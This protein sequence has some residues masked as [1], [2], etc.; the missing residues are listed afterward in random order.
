MIEEFAAGPVLETFRYEVDVAGL[1]C[2][3]DEYTGSL[4]GLVTAD[5]E[6]PDERFHHA[7]MGGQGDYRQPPLQLFGI[8]RKGGWRHARIRLTGASEHRLVRQS[9]R[10][11]VCIS[12]FQVVARHSAPR[13]ASVC[14]KLDLVGKTSQHC[15]EGRHMS[16]H[17][18][19]LVRRPSR[20][21]M[22]PVAWE[23][24]RQGPQHLGDHTRPVPVKRRP[25]PSEQATAAAPRFPTP[26]MKPC[27]AKTRSLQA[28]GRAASSSG[29][30]R[31]I[32]SLD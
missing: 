29:S 17:P 2:Q 24:Y 12:L 21:P 7:I 28:I 16:P 6:L 13:C 23:S 14:P 11:K 1:T 18:L 3:I 5:V 9:S 4:R 26:S 27:R 20:W 10:G 30:G 22:P 32:R 19:P 15:A 8:S 25:R 31:T